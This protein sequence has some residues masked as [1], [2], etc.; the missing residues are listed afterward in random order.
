[1]S[2]DERLT[3]KPETRLHQ[4]FTHDLQNLYRK[5][6]QNAKINRSR[7]T[8]EQSDAPRCDKSLAEQVRMQAS[9]LNERRRR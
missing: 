8:N 6:L 5:S 2:L 7:P 1:M 3:V 9:C 4:I